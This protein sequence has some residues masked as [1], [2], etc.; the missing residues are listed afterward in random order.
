MK[1][2][3]LSHWSDWINL[4]FDGI[5]SL[6]FPRLE[7]RSPSTD[8]SILSKPKPITLRMRL[9]LYFS[10]DLN[11]CCC[12]DMCY[13]HIPSLCLW[14]KIKQ[15]REIVDLGYD[16][17]NHFACT[18]S[19]YHVF[20]NLS[21]LEKAHSF[22]FDPGLFS[23]PDKKVTCFLLIL[24]INRNGFQSQWQVSQK[25]SSLWMKSFGVT[26]NENLFRGAF[27]RYYVIFSVFNDFSWNVIFRKNFLMSMVYPSSPLLSPAR[28]VFRKENSL[29][30]S[31]TSSFKTILLSLLF[32]S[33]CLQRI[34][35]EIM[36]REAFWGQRT[37]DNNIAF[38]C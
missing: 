29:V 3:S 35:H 15:K 31:W 11:V 13:I 34:I 26:I 18:V 36:E 10:F 23:S 1:R 27:T 19:Y 5:C 16:L 12:K 2:I 20:G 6:Q 8:Q 24:H 37:A 28:S 9:F 25:C 7:A 33:L 38:L 30:P 4:L 32:S 21:C 14:R 17:G 22:P